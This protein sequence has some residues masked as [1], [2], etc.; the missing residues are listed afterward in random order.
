MS[1]ESLLCGLLRDLELAANLGPRVALL[2]AQL[3]VVPEKSVG[4][5]AQRC[6]ERGRRGEFLQ[7]RR[8]WCGILD[9]L[10]EV[11]EIQVH[12]VNHTLTIAC[13][14]PSV[15]DGDIELTTDGPAHSS[16]VDHA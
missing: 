7:G 1:D 11:I 13:R 5:V 4:V 3:D 12:A 15:D 10:H 2:S 16:I 9:C 8:V 6:A 14:Q